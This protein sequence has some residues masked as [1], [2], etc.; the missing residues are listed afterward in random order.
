MLHP[1]ESCLEFGA[2]EDTPDLLERQ[3][4]QLAHH[5]EWNFKLLSSGSGRTGGESLS[6]TGA[7]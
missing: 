6:V 7:E 5:G 4:L 2:P 3:T 1:D